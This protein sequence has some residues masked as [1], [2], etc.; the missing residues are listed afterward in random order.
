MLMNNLAQL[1]DACLQF[2]R[3]LQ[4]QPP[5]ALKDLVEPVYQLFQK[6]HER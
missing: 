4:D 1:V 2:G 3:Q 6:F 5:A